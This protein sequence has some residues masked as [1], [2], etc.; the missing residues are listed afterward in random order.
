MLDLM[1]KAD[2]CKLL[3][4]SKRTFDRWRSMWRAKGVDVGE[5][6]IRKKAL[7]RRDRIEKLALSPRL[8]LA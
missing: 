6:K 4:C 3:H 2:V 7:F 1:T 5:V 8:W